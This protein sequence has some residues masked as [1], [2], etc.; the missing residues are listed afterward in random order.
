MDLTICQYDSTPLQD[1]SFRGNLGWRPCRDMVC[2]SGLPKILIPKRSMQVFVHYNIRLY[3]HYRRRPGR[4]MFRSSSQWFYLCLGCG[5]RWSKICTFLWLYCCL[6]VYHR[7]DDIRCWKLPGKCIWSITQ[8]STKGS[9]RLRITLC[10]SL[11]YSRLVFLEA[12]DL[13]M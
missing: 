4:N 3:D 1:C 8:S 9:R 11:R 6:V 13:R 7:L 12:L 2:F 10:L 5:E